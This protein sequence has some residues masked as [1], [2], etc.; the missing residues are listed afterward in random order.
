MPTQTDM[1]LI[2]TG[3]GLYAVIV[4]LYAI[5]KKLTEK[6]EN[7]L[8]EEYGECKSKPRKMSIFPYLVILAVVVVL[9]L[10]IYKLM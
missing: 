5:L 6:Q 3:V 7:N 2:L 1:V 10:L 9:D 4:L 8:L